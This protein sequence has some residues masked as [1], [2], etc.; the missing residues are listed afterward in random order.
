MALEVGN[1]RIPIEKNGDIV[2]YFN[3]VQ[4]R[5]IIHRV[6]LKIRAADGEYVITKGDNDE[7]NPTVDQDCYL[8]V[9]TYPFPVPMDH[10][11]GRVIFVIPRIG[12][13]KLWLLGP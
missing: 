7:T 8:G 6:V 2:V 3:D 12:I 5:D 13:I 11:F 10:V 9:C 4:G 1:K